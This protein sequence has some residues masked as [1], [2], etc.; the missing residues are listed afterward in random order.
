MQLEKMI[1]TGVVQ[2]LQKA[3]RL[4][5]Q[6]TFISSSDRWH[7]ADR[8]AGQHKGDTKSQGTLKLPQLFLHMQSL[9]LNHESYNPGSLS[10]MG[11][12]GQRRENSNT[13]RRYTLLPA[14]YTFELIHISQDFWDMFKF[15]RD[16]VLH[17]IQRSDVNFTVNWDGKGLDVRVMPDD[18]LSTPDKDASVDVINTYELTANLQVLGWIAAEDA[19]NIPLVQRTTADLIPTLTPPVLK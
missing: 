19:D 5:E 1:L 7:L 2:R 10:M 4:Q 8:I 3:F 11:T 6:P 9:G 12:Y 18:T 14:V 17:R 16:Y 13:V 15:S